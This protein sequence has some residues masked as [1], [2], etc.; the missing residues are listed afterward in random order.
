VRIPEDY[1]Y[2]EGHFPGYPILPGA[3][4][5]AELVLPCVRQ[6]RP[7]LGPMRGMSQLKFLGRILPGDEVVV[8]LTFDQGESMVDFT[9]RTR[10]LVASTGRLAFA[11]AGARVSEN[12]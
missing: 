12:D 10:T 9:L 7:D 6:A 4:Q 3:V 11:P 1:A 8:L 5:L 2:F